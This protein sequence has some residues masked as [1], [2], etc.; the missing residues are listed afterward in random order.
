M[1]KPY[2]RVG[3]DGVQ[4]SGPPTAESDSQEQRFAVF[5][6]NAD[7]VVHSSEIKQLLSDLDRVGRHFTLISIPSEVSWGKA[8]TA[9]V[10]AV[11]QHNVLG[12]IALDRN[13]S[14]L[15][16]Q[17]G[18][19]AFVPVIAI[20]SDKML[21]STNIPWI[22]RFRPARRHRT[23]YKSS[24]KLQNRQERIVGRFVIFWRLERRSREL[25]LAR[26]AKCGER[27]FPF[28]PPSAYGNVLIGIPRGSNP[29][30]TT[31][32][33]PTATIAVRKAGKYL[34]AAAS[35]SA[36]VVCAIFCP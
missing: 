28:L 29:S 17:I 10:Q 9:L 25:A 3:E 22:F 34:F 27:C 30:R 2:A 35:T 12:I 6:P 19:K 33:S 5:G 20:S 23:E 26:Q 31:F 15:A 24:Q 11:Y 18:V 1:E 16:E 8:S 36:L 21:T 13:S 4:Y 7:A 14:H 32:S